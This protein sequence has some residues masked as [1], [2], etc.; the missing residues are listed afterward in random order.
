MVLLSL[1]GIKGIIKRDIDSHFI[2]ANIDSDVIVDE[3][4]PQG[5]TEKPV[6]LYRVIER[7]Y[8]GRKRIELFGEDRN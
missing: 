3:E 1:V 4:P 6:E 7:F 8:I 5:S 2:H